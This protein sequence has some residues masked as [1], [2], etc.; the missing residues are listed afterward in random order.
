[1]TGLT[2]IEVIG[3]W[4]C[5]KC[6]INIVRLD[7]EEKSEALLDYLELYKSKFMLVPASISHHHN[8]S[9]G[10]LRHTVEVTQI[11]IDIA[12][13]DGV[14]YDSISDVIMAAILHDIGDCEQYEEIDGRWQ[15]KEG[16]TGNFHETFVVSDWDSKMDPKLLSDAVRN[17][18]LTHHGGWS[19]TKV[20]M[21]GVL[22]AILHGAD[23]I[24]SR[25]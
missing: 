1:M 25:L 18:L 22:S 19:T 23:L 7:S 21:N 10:L 15:Y 5:L 17:A 11:A 14:M 13:S 16:I 3:Y 8:Y 12:K 24:S 9:G 6:V 20:D 2:S 4:D